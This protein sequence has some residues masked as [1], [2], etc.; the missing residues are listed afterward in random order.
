M[1]QGDES[2]LFCRDDT[3]P[4][5]GVP[6]GY[7][8]I[9]PLLLQQQQSSSG[10]HTQRRTEFEDEVLQDSGETDASPEEDNGTSSALVNLNNG[11]ESDTIDAAPMAAESDS[12]PNT[13]L[14]IVHDQVNSQSYDESEDAAGNENQA[15]ADD[16]FSGSREPPDDGYEQTVEVAQPQQGSVGD[17]SP[18]FC[19]EDTPPRSGVPPGYESLRSVIGRRVHERHGAA[20]SPVAQHLPVIPEES[21]GSVIEQQQPTQVYPTSQ[22]SS[23]DRV[24]F[25]GQPLLQDQRTTGS[26][27]D[28]TG[29]QRP[30]PRPRPFP[31]WQPASTQS[32]AQQQRPILPYVFQPSSVPQ[33]P[34][35]IT[36]AAPLITKGEATS[37]TAVY[38]SYSPVTTSTAEGLYT[39]TD[40]QVYWNSLGRPQC[41][42]MGCDN[43]QGIGYRSE[44]SRDQ[45]IS[46]TRFH[47]EVPHLGYEQTKRGHQNG[48]DYP[49]LHKMASEEFHKIM[50]DLREREKRLND[51]LAALEDESRAYIRDHRELLVAI[52]ND[53]GPTRPPQHPV[54]E[55]LN[56]FHS[57][58]WVGPPAVPSG[59]GTQPVEDEDSLF[60]PEN[61]GNSLSIPENAGEPLFVPDNAEDSLF[62]PEDARVDE[63]VVEPPPRP[64]RRVTFSDAPVT[65]L[66]ATSPSE[67]V[68]FGDPSKADE[69]FPLLSPSNDVNIG[70]N[71]PTYTGSAPVEPEDG[72][73]NATVATQESLAFPATS[74]DTNMG[75][76]PPVYTASNPISSENGH[77]NTAQESFTLPVTPDDTVMG[78][79]QPIYTGNRRTSKRAR[80]SSRTPRLMLNTG[81]TPTLPDNKPATDPQEF[82]GTYDPQNFA[83]AYN[84][85]NL[86]DIHNP[87]DFVGTYNPLDLAGT[88]N[89]QDFPGAYNPQDFVNSYSPGIPTGGPIEP[90]QGG[91]YH[92]MTAESELPDRVDSHFVCPYPDC[93][94]L[95]V[96]SGDVEQHLEHNHPDW[97]LI[98]DA[99]IASDTPNVLSLPE[100]W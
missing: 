76:D 95:Y 48:R 44:Y 63:P 78:F 58:Q 10:H 88:Y 82:V 74:D 50:A 42:K 34:V 14:S 4:R 31:T 87:Q 51:N 15:S 66:S 21:R 32:L 93:G 72:N 98:K 77:V 55:A 53:Q 90:W 70:Y 80:H 33:T 25:S 49:L 92:D 30:Q 36:L 8:S 19:R 86:A 40:A 91:E 57:T 47:K 99:V 61:A 96:N 64:K 71:Q 69:S 3:P 56:T 16:S 20:Q 41:F 59:D 13:F 79:D 81:F 29:P 12:V 84:P 24:A 38:P 18:L 22:H 65:I 23:T 89:S 52:E 28:L 39:L 68:G 5:S 26:R 100:H 83:G 1:N 11:H 37:G 67:N 35:E 62:V 27:L 54:A 45:H 60:V 97:A 46:N 17:E 6:P 2:P 75:F 7:V 85:Q 43:N 94:K 9:R 73:V